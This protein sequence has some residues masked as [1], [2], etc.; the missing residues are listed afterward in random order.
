MWN[1]DSLAAR[2]FSRILI[3]ESLQAVHKFHILAVCESSLNE[4]IPNEN[5]SIHCFSPDPF[6]ADKP[7]TAHNGGVCL[8]FKGYLPIKR[9]ADLE[10]LEET[11]VAEI[12][13]IYISYHIA[14]QIKQLRHH[15][16]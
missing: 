14:I 5:I 2:E 11:I 13:K 8:Y 1:L 9:R 15:K 6:R 7:F 3:V 10:H 12:S 4:F 16:P